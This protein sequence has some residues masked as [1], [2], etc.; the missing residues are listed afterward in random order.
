MRLPGALLAIALTLAGC[1]APGVMRPRGPA[2][3]A[4]STLAPPAWEAP[5]PHG[6]EAADLLR[7]WARFD[8][9]VLPALI[10]SAQ[11]AHPSLAAAA[12]RVAQAR[13][14]ATAAGAGLLPRVD[15]V[16]QG[17]RGRDVP[18]APLATSG[19]LGAAFSWE[20]D[21]FGAVGAGR[22]AARARLRAAQA[23]WHDARV[24][25]AAE[26][27]QQYLALRACEAQLDLA[28]ADAASRAQT[29]RLTGTLAE[30][31]LQAPA[32]AAL[33]RAS[34]AQAASGLVVREASCQG[35]VKVLVELTALPEPTLRARLAPGRARVPPAPAL[36]ASLPAALL[37][38]RPDIAAAAAQAQ[39]AADAVVQSRAQ[40]LPRLSLSGNFTR[41]RA[42]TAFA[43]Q[44]GP[45][46]SFG[47]VQLTLP[48]F[49]GGR[50]QA[51]EASA[52]AAYT[53]AEAQ[54]KA[55]IRQAVR[56]VEQALVNLDA[57]QRRSASVRSAAADYRLSLQGAEIRQRA[58][59][60][61]LFELEDARRSAVQADAA[62]IDWQRE[63]AQAWVALYRALGGGWQADAATP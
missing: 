43:T 17:T 9:P 21:L 29:D 63:H 20:L 42:E 16:A 56:E 2:P 51:A 19:A 58:G 10:E 24:L 6:G 35:L 12:A 15:A 32:V 26:V 50:L 22:D 31:G 25:V 28:R 38:Q 41:A 30:V 48:L 34:A 55:R 59:L 8:D 3:P 52:R 44:Q 37:A 36:T 4:A 47:P 1:A 23:G 18:E 40:R 27:A 53:E 39:A 61:S 49:D 13:A 46:W 14:D 7:W 54:L 60:A 45:V 33:A 62:W 11:A 57:A 5:L